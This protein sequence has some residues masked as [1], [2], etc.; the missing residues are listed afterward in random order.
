MEAE[1][2]LDEG[3]VITSGVVP[4]INEPVAL[5]GTSEKGYLSVELKSAFVG[6]HSSMPQAETANLCFVGRNFENNRK[7]TSSGFYGIRLAGFLNYIGPEIPWPARIGFLQI[8]GLLG[9]VLKKYLYTGTGPGKC[10]CANNNRP[11]HVECRNKR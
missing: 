11:N 8:A 3:M 4:M 10:N 5:I 2:V 9:G 6:G 7:P 1:M